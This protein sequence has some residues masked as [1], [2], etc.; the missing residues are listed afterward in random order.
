MLFPYEASQVHAIEITCMLALCNAKVFWIYK[1]TGWT[2][3]LISFYISS[4]LLLKGKDEN[5]H[6]D[7][8]IINTDNQ[9]CSYVHSSG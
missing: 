4:L 2:I 3:G 7:Y 8:K 9:V 1:T 5:L 6:G